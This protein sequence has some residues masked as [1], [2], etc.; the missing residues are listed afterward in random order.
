MTTTVINLTRYR[1]EEV[2]QVVKDL[3][4]Q[5]LV[6]GQDFDFAWQQSRWDEMIGEIPSSVEFRFYDSRLASW[7]SL[8]WA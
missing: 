7:F 4:Q 5:G 6:Q 2:L 1:V 3:R 8:K